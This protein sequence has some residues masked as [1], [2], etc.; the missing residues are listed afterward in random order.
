MGIQGNI[1]NNYLTSIYEPDLQLCLS[2]KALK[3][4][5][6]EAFS[7]GEQVSRSTDRAK[8]LG[9]REREGERA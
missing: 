1:I 8:Q 3:L 6:P 9:N 2:P 7:A 4:F 5:L